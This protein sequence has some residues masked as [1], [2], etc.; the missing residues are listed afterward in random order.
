MTTAL[1]AD[2]LVTGS[3]VT[4]EHPLIHQFEYPGVADSVWVISSMA[5][6]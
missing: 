1:I 2:V 5:Y 6:S 3:I 4:T